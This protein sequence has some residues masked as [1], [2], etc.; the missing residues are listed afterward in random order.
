MLSETSQQNTEPWTRLLSPWKH[1]PVF[2]DLCHPCYPKMSSGRTQSQQHLEGSV[3]GV[4][5]FFVQEQ[6]GKPEINGFCVCVGGGDN[7]GEAWKERAL[8]GQEC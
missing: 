6:V 4:M 1:Q 3:K 8:W 5:M 2:R 7:V